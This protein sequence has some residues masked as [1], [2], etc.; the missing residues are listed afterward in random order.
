M[1]VTKDNLH[2]I[3]T[4]AEKIKQLGCSSFSATPMALNMDF[5]R[6]DLLLSEDEIR[7]VIADLL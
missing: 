3:R 5:P 4:T 6:L 2:E 7:Q 1:V